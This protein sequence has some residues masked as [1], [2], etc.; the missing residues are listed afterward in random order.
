MHRSLLMKKMTDSEA[1]RGSK[2]DHVGQ[3]CETRGLLLLECWLLA[4]PAAGDAV[5]TLEDPNVLL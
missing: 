2:Q 5:Q 1:A 3:L 4:V